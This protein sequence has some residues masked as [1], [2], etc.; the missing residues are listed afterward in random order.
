LLPWLITG[1]AL[2]AQN[3]GVVPDQPVVLLPISQYFLASIVGLLVIGAALAGP[4]ARILRHRRPR[5]GGVVL[6][7][8]VLPVQAPSADPSRLIS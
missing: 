6:V 2:P 1:A 5:F 3:L 7:A 8:G 4:A